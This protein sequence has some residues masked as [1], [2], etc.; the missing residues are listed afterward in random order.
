M[1]QNIS[2][3]KF[4]KH[5][6]SFM[7]KTPDGK[8]WFLNLNLALFAADIPY[9]KKDG[10][11]VSASHIQ[12]IKAKNQ[13]IYESIVNRAQIKTSNNGSQK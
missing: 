8:T 2:S 12:Q 9:T 4:I 7:L 3:V 5:S 13:K 10:T 1:S 11:F 6:N